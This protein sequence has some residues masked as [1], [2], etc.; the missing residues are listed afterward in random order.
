MKK[1]VSYKQ[2]SAEE[3]T[4]NKFV[5]MVKNA[6]QDNRDGDESLGAWESKYNTGLGSVSVDV[7]GYHVVYSEGTPNE[8]HSWSPKDNFET[9]YLEIGEEGVKMLREAINHVTVQAVKEVTALRE[10]LIS[11]FK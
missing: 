10:K 5:E 6:Y 9:G 2:V 8:Y 7:P 1:Y 3:M 11:V 4:R